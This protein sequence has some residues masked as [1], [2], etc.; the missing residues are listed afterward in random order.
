[1]CGPTG[2]SQRAQ[3]KPR[4]LPDP[5]PPAENLESWRSTFFE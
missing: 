5:Q 1:M 4:P 2:R 3:V